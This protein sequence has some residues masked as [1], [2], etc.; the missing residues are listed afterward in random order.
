MQGGDFTL[1]VGLFLALG[2]DN[3]LRGIGHE[4]LVAELLLHTGKKALSVLQLLLEF[5]DFLGNVDVVV[6]WNGKLGS[7]NQERC[8]SGIF[9]LHNL[10]RVET[11]ELEDD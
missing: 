1:S 8:C 2:G 6:E 10:D 4:A 3:S 11:G 7:S 5:L 9:A